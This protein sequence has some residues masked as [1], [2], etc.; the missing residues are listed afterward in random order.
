MPKLELT[1]H[2]RSALRA[3]AHPLRPVVLI[4]DKG[5][6]ES[7]LQEIDRSLI[8]H[9]L[10]KVRVGGAERETRAA[11]LETICDALS[12][13]AVHHLGKTLII[14]RPDTAAQ[15]AQAEAHNTT[16]AV[17]KP[18]E[19]YIPKKQAAQERDKPK[20]AASAKPRKAGAGSAPRKSDVPASQERRPDAPSR[21][22]RRPA[23]AGVARRG[24]ASALTLRAGIRRGRATRS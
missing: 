9:E 20:A 19:P 16:R 17:R 21:I 8:A 22:P 6:S 11:M 18:S 13:A 10:V 23:A 15:Q 5:L 4:G 14:Y 7:V 1:S 12:C 3:A 2:E 24:G